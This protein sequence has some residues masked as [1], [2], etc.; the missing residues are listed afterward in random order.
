MRIAYTRLCLTAIFCLVALPVPAQITE[1]SRSPISSMSIVGYDPDTGEVGVAMA[2]RF[3][4]VAPIA[5]HVRADV[6]AIATMGWSPYKD[7]NEMMDWLEE[8]ASP[9]EIIQRL[10][11]RYGDTWGGGQINIVDVEGRSIAVTGNESMWKGHRIGTN[12]ATSGNILAGPEVVDAFADTFEGTDGSDMPLAERLLR[13]LVA[14][15]R[16]GGDARGRMG[17]TLVVKKKRSGGVSPGNVDDYVNL[18]VDNS[19]SAIHDLANLYY[20]WRSIR[21]QEPGFR[22]MEQSRGG[23]VR[24]LQESLARLGYLSPDDREIFDAEGQASGVLDAATAE[25]LVR[26]KR[27]HLLGGTPSAGLEVV[28]AIRRELAGRLPQ[29]VGLEDTKDMIIYQRNGGDLPRRP[30]P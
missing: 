28:N 13:A 12:Y 20:R 16:A 21:N 2:S 8:G 10:R 22:V 11:D 19:R 27:D 18:R 14:A 7:A 5:V 9:Q 24:W 26:Y 17:A 23:D 3:F 15:D 1:P 29:V 30:G 25:G 4:A 6:G